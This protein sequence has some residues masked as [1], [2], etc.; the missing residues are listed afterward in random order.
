MVMPLTLARNRFGF[1]WVEVGPRDWEV[2]VRMRNLIS[3]A[4]LRTM[5]VQQ[6]EQARKEIERLLE[7]AVSGRKN[8]P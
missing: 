6:R 4:L 2:Y 5:L 1:M 7:D 8:W 3:S